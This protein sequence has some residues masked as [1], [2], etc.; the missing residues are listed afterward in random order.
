[1]NVSITMSLLSLIDFEF[2]FL[3]GTLFL[4]CWWL[5]LGYL[6]F[7]YLHSSLSGKRIIP[8]TY[9]E[10]DQPSV[11]MIIP[12][13][14]EENY[15]KQKIENCLALKYSKEKISFVFSDGQSSDKTREIIKKYQKKHH[16]IKLHISEKRGKIF[17]LNSALQQIQSDI[18]VVSDCDALL[19]TNALHVIVSYLAHKNVG[20]VGISSEPAECTKEEQYFWGQQN[21]LRLAESKFYSPLYVIAT[22]YGFR[23]DLLSHFP[24]DVIAD[25][26]Y[27]SFY[28]VKKGY[29]SLYTDDSR[30][31]ELRNPTTLVG[32]FQHKIRKTN[33]F[34]V[35]LKRYFFSFLRADAAWQLIFYTHFFQIFLA[36]FL[37]PLLFFV[38]VY[39][40]MVS[41]TKLL[42][43]FTLSLLIFT[44]LLIRPEALKG[45]FMKLKTFAL[46]HAVLYY[47][48]LTFP[49]YRQTSSYKK[50]K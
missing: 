20:V 31:I 11:T 25:D 17:Q 6:I 16:S 27:L 19:E 10:K 44:Y 47:C 23:K 14:N 42:P 35:E 49:F 15:I 18:V 5:Y 9:E 32:L 7:I 48:L 39:L 3:Y 8:A 36:P 29:R 41:L 50:V 1:M 26:I 22:C 21:R 28:A 34:L 38:F 40:A 33:A 37:A 46:L 43:I 30:V 4:I 13:Y 24:E 45:I 12:C 2:L